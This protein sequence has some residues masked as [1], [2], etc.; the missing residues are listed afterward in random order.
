MKRLLVPLVIAVMGLGAGVGA[1]IALKPAPEEQAEAATDCA[2]PPCE[3]AAQDPFAPPV[4]DGPGE[5]VDL[6]YVPL[7]KPFVVPVFDGDKVVAMVV[8]SLSVEVPADHEPEARVGAIEPRLRDAL[9]KA[10]FLHANSDGF[11]GTFT[12]GRKIA[13]LKA[14]L[15]ASARQVMGQEGVFD[16]LITEIARQDV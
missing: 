6:A 1:G 2:Q 9:L 14:S 3:E 7:Q 13:D 15:L 11:N 4:H 8:L 5:D 10:M 16:V 12:T